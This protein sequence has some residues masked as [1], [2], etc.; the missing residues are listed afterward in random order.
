MNRLQLARRT[1]IL[2]LLV[3]GNSLRAASRLAD[4]SLNTVMKLLA[5]VG[6]A[7]AHYQDKTLRGLKCQRVQCDE[8]WSFVGA[9]QKNATKGAIGYG[10]V[11]TWTALDADTKLI[12]AWMVGNRNAESAKSFIKDLSE[13]LT[14]RVQISTDGLR[15]YVN[16]IENA[17][18]GDVDYAQI[19]K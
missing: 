18:G 10:D 11:W 8:I 15:L 5:D 17:F 6:A 13:R 19:T 4:V 3:E 1:Q 14:N 2:S 16:A 7:S 12:A 9:K